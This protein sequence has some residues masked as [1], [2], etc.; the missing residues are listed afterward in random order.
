M[1][2]TIKWMRKYLTILFVGNFVSLAFNTLSENNQ[3]SVSTST[4]SDKLTFVRQQNNRISLVPNYGVF[5]ASAQITATLQSINELAKK[6][7]EETKDQFPT[8]HEEDV[9]KSITFLLDKITSNNRNNKWYKQLSDNLSTILYS[10]ILSGRF[11][12]NSANNQENNQLPIF[13]YLADNRQKSLLKLDDPNSQ[14][15]FV[16]NTLTQD[17]KSQFAHRF[18]NKWK[19]YLTTDSNKNSKSS[20][21]SNKFGM[22]WYQSIPQSLRPSREYNVPLTEDDYQNLIA[23]LTTTKA[24][25]QIILKHSELDQVQKEVE[26]KLK[27]KLQTDLASLE[28][29]KTNSNQNKTLFFD[30]SAR[31]LALNLGT[32]A[33]N[34]PSEEETKEFTANWNTHFSKTG[35]IHLDSNF[36]LTNGEIAQAS[37]SDLQF[38]YQNTDG[39]PNNNPPLEWIL[40]L[41]N[42]VLK[43]EYQF[44]NTSNP[45]QTTQFI[46]EK[47]F[48]I[49]QKQKIT[50]LI[51]LTPEAANS[52]RTE[53]QPN[54]FQLTPM[55]MQVLQKLSQLL[56]LDF[57]ITQV[58]SDFTAKKDIN[59]FE[60]TIQASLR[61]YG[62]APDNNLSLGS[63][64]KKFIY[65]IKPDL[66][67]QIINQAP[68]IV[69]VWN[70]SVE[71]RSEN[72]IQELLAA[73]NYNQYFDYPNADS[74]LNYVVTEISFDTANVYVTTAIT[75]KNK[76]ASGYT[77]KY[78]S[79]LP[80]TLFIDEAKLN[81]LAKI[82][83]EKINN[84]FRWAYGDV[85][86]TI[87]DNAKLNQIFEKVLTITKTAPNF[88]ESAIDKKIEAFLNNYQ[89]EL[90]SQIQKNNSKNNGINQEKINEYYNDLRERLKEALIKIGISL[91]SNFAK[92]L[93]EQIDLT[94]TEA[95]NN[96]S[97]QLDPRFLEIINFIENSD[98]N[99]DVIRSL[100][101]LLEHFTPKEIV[102]VLNDTQRTVAY[103]FTGISS[104]ILLS[105]IGLIIQG[106]KIDSQKYRISKSVVIGVGIV[107][108]LISTGGLGYLISLLAG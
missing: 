87:F 97:T 78:I 6:K 27:Q 51:N 3:Q 37:I 58:N 42:A 103:S 60:L 59:E 99:L 15:D 108:S 30:T 81:E 71:I 106:I 23:A 31:T 101:S 2:K 77:K 26:V 21:S 74:N 25:S 91:D 79:T 57:E 24:N 107:L 70:N 18:L 8:S 48:A 104:A 43:G 69:P 52:L 1:K 34:S 11:L 55:A 47:I 12:Y 35:N 100:N 65:T 41:N 33:Q 36:F 67:D 66:E 46:L 53:F 16:I 96:Q 45:A 105:S 94:E 68:L 62:S 28:K 98:K 13:S 7:I 56:K 14:P 86:D 40:I 102:K 61:S 72:Q 92:S 5:N 17:E 39:T 90:L 93:F 95:L 4:K 50:D 38:K 75:L 49:I 44:S 80:I 89:N 76:Y 88:Q 85:F 19:T 63:L 20:S 10:N 82:A 73:G 29:A 84:N 32:I 64:T 22:E 54:D 9:A 83:A